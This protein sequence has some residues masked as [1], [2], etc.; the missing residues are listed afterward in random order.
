MSKAA[1]G[2]THN[3][4]HL[5]VS[6]LSGSKNFTMCGECLAPA[7]RHLPFEMNVLYMCPPIV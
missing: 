4:L 1:T 7:L 2:G 5:V 6:Q 3:D